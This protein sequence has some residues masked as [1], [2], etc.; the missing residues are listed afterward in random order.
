MFQLSFE[1]FWVREPLP[2]Q[3]CV[4]VDFNHFHCIRE[5]RLVCMKCDAV[6]VAGTLDSAPELIFFLF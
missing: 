6:P 1:I 5:T 3:P 4:L 2:E